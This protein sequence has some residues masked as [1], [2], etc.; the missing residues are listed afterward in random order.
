MK[1]EAMM[2]DAEM[3]VLAQNEEWAADAESDED[4]VPNWQEKRETQKFDAREIRLSLAQAQL[5]KEDIIADGECAIV[6]ET[7]EWTGADSDGE[8][9]ASPTKLDNTAKQAFEAREKRLTV[10]SQQLD[11]EAMMADIDVAVASETKEWAGAGD[12]DD[13]EG[14]NHLEQR[15]T[16][17]FNDREKRITFSEEQMKREMQL[18][19][20]EVAMVKEKKE[21]AAAAD[22]SDEEGPEKRNQRASQAF[23]AREQRLTAGAASERRLSGGVSQDIALALQ[24]VNSE[25]AE[26]LPAA[27]ERF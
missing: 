21:W 6:A 22:D 20:A 11:K 24:Q 25:M 19:D 10:A 1:K 4:E 7:K 5:E 16:Q 12:S 23:Q 13:E 26:V 3:K 2:S 8:G 9:D 18:A 17:A 14:P 15:A 27:S